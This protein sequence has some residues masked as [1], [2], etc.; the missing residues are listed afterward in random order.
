MVSVNSLSGGKTSSYLA[1]HYPADY[2]IFSLVR[3]KDPCC[4]PKDKG[5]I[6]KVQEKLQVDFVASAEDDKTLKVMLDL[7]Q[8]LGREIIW[9]SGPTFDD[10]IQ[11][12]RCL[13]NMMWRFCTQ[14]M[15]LQPIFNWWF[16]NIGEKVKMGIGFRFDEMERKDRFSIKYKYKAGTNLFGQK[17]HIWET[18]EWREGYFP[19]IDDRIGHYTVNEFWKGKRLDFPSDSNCVG[20]FWKQVPQLR[21][22][23]EDNPVKM[24]WF[25]SQEKL[26][27][28]TF[29]KDTTY[30]QIK[31][32]GIQQD[33][34]FGGGSGCQAGFCTD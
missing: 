30:N 28:K 10:V 4:S 24:G 33:F 16:Q 34:L 14:E 22:N 1:V 13:P 5:L 8:L 2:E 17:R 26:I 11:Q 31:E 27:G 15:K 21:K 20:C 12:R 19:L 9:V 6:K 25:A 29:K 32:I 3:I 18:I 23:W 7:E